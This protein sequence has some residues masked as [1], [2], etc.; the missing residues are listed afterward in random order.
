M[1]INLNDL[2]KYPELLDFI[3]VTD[4]SLMEDA[5]E[6]LQPVYDMPC[7]YQD[8]NTDDFIGVY[9]LTPLIIISA[10]GFSDHLAFL[11]TQINPND[12]VLYSKLF[13]PSLSVSI[14][15]FQSF[16]NKKSCNYAAHGSRISNIHHDP[17]EPVKITDGFFALRA[18]AHYGHLRIM[19]QLLLV[20]AYKKCLTLLGN[21]ILRTAVMEGHEHLVNFLLGQG[22]V[23][24]RLQEG[25]CLVLPAA[26][27]PASFKIME[28]LLAIKP[29]IFDIDY[30]EGSMPVNGHACS[31][32]SPKLYYLQIAII[33]NKDEFI[34][35]LCEFPQIKNR[36]AEKDNYILRL[37]LHH[38]KYDFANW[39]LDI[40]EVQASLGARNGRVLHV[41]A[42]S[43]NDDIVKRLLS[44]QIVRE[45][46]NS[47]YNKAIYL[48]AANGY[49]NIVKCLL[50]VLQVA[51]EIK[52]LHHKVLRAAYQGT[53]DEFFPTKARG[54]HIAVIELLMRYY[55]E[56]FIV[57][58][59][60]QS[61]IKQIQP[62]DAIIPGNDK[63]LVIPSSINL[64]M[65][66]PSYDRFGVDWNER[67]YDYRYSE[68]LE[69]DGVTTTS[70]DGPCH[71]RLAARYK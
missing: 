42:Q 63:L 47:E 26:M 64:K 54:P 7:S 57:K 23:I 50:E 9:K 25:H 39:L 4:Q 55:P 15:F 11:L 43:G 67:L 65:N 58:S 31:I 33:E 40:P 56:I 28:T 30:Q 61:T 5:F 12:G 13:Y 35:A 70:I 48:A 59:D 69:D 62:T 6:K 8:A 36:L 16:F 52:G 14:S 19:K 60:D 34:K 46:A 21:I 3:N 49:T 2:E 17:R 20:P 1:K 66:N 32:E 24:A 22:S 29:S 38:K 45:Q 10:L 44:F 41:A 71:F 68:I 37:A 27:K 53:C 18:A 51:E